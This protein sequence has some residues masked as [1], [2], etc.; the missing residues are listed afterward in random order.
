MQTLSEVTVPLQLLIDLDQ[1]ITELMP[2]I[3]ML[4]IQDYAHL[5]ETLMALSA[6]IAKG[7]DSA[8]FKEGED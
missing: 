7:R 3:R 4:T 8:N 2:G 6:A 1:V 5:N